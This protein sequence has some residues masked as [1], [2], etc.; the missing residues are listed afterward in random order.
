[1]SRAKKSEQRRKSKPPEAVTEVNMNVPLPTLVPIVREGVGR[2]SGSRRAEELSRKYEELQ[3]VLKA[4]GAVVG[5][6]D[7]GSRL[8]KARVLLGHNQTLAG[9]KIGLSQ[10][11]ISQIERGQSQTHPS[12]KKAIEDYI[13][14]TKRS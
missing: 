13:E 9:D 5:P 10:K 7:L 8:K 3:G 1:M 12:T 11:Q 2:I 14:A 4:S 6:Q